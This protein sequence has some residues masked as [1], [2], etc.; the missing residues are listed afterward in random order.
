MI[1]SV[2]ISDSSIYGS[3]WTTPELRTLFTEQ[4]RVQGWL[5][6]MT[7]LAETQAQFGV[8]PRQAAVEIRRFY[9]DLQITR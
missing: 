2:H 7:V 4:A 9:D 1:N 3:S 6:V 5:E 8:I